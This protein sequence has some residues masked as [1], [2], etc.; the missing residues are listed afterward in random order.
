VTDDVVHF[1]R[2][3]IEAGWPRRGTRL[4]A[5]HESAVTPEAAGAPKNVADLQEKKS[6]P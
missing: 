4:G 5:E 3:A 6:V 2:H 1:V